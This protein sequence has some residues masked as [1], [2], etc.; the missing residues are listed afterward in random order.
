MSSHDYQALQQISLT[1]WAFTS[2]VQPN[3]MN[4]VSWKKKKKPQ[5]TSM[6]MKFLSVRGSILNI[7]SDSCSELGEVMFRI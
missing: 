3:I 6:V 1:Q 4:S 5:P 7:S 2:N